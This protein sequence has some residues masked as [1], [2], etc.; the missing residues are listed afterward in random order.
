MSAKALVYADLD[1]RH[2]H[3][4]LYEEDGL[5]SEEV[6]YLVRT[7]LSEGQIRY[8][9]VEKTPQGRMAAREIVRPGPTGLIT[10]LTKGLTKEDNETR[11]FSLY[12]DDSKGHTLRV[13]QALA[14]REA[15]GPFP[16]WTLPPG[17]L[18]TSS[19][20]RRRWW[21]LTPRPSPG[22]WRPRTSPRT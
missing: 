1:F 17:T 21:S 19:F 6:L 9:T 13:V 20:L 2:R 16:R 8:L 12:M 18:S 4:V 15:R 14:E 10:T 5:S 3:L 11:T 22:F 7:L